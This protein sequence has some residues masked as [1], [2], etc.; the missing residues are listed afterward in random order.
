[1]KEERALDV[2]PQLVAFSAFIVVVLPS[3]RE[4]LGQMTHPVCCVAVF[5]TKTLKWSANIQLTGDCEPPRT[6]KDIGDLLDS[7]PAGTMLAWFP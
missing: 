7:L 6:Q 5:E 2:H 4:Q 3:I 1:M